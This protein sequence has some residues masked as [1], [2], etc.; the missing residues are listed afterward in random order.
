MSRIDLL[1]CLRCTSSLDAL[2]ASGGVVQQ[3]FHP[4]SFFFHPHSQGDRSTAV[5]ATVTSMAW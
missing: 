3:I 5:A 4:L 2:E 1:L